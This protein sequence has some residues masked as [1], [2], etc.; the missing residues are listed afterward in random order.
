MSSRICTPGGPLRNCRNR[1]V[2][3]T[4]YLMFFFIQSGRLSRFISL[5]WA[6][7][8][9][10]LDSFL[11]QI[12]IAIPYQSMSAIIKFGIMMGNYRKN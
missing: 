9:E 10:G 11:Q 8:M 7:W 1:I 5:T 2:I 6:F 3:V 12:I 4:F